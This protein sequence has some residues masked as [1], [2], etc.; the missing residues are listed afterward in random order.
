MIGA[1]GG[2]KIPAEQGTHSSSIHLVYECTA[3]FI[4]RNAQQREARNMG[5]WNG[6]CFIDVFNFDTKKPA[7][8]AIFL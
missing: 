8:D 4:Y 1:E 7:C 2:R 5:K 3:K 6:L